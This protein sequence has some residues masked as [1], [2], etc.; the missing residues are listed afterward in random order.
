MSKVLMFI[1][2]LSISLNAALGVLVW[3]NN[4]EHKNLYGDYIRLK[5]DYMSLHETHQIFLNKY[6]DTVDAYKDIVKHLNR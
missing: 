2:V 4:T 6:Y 5:A 1:L 3:K